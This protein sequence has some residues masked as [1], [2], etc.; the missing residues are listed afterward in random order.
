MNTDKSPTWTLSS[1]LSPLFSPA[2]STFSTPSLDFCIAV[3]A[4]TGLSN[5]NTWGQLLLS[6]YFSNH[7]PLQIEESSYFTYFS[8]KSLHTSLTF[9]PSFIL[10]LL[11]LPPSY[12]SYFS[13]LLHTSLTFPP[14]FILVI[15]FLCP[16]LSSAPRIA[17][18][19]MTT[20]KKDI[21]FSAA[22][23]RLL[24]QPSPR[25]QLLRN[26]GAKV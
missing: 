5:P 18:Y 20:W 9:H 23:V 4:T 14:S 26:W 1:I 24:G 2:V 10:V 12:F 19:I 15:S 21:I 6:S 11:F 16:H 8:L 22:Q 25:V 7:C 13:S 17:I 3:C